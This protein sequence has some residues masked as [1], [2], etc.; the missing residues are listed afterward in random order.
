MSKIF[1]YTLIFVFI[2]IF[3][4]SLSLILQLKGKRLTKWFGKHTF[5]IHMLITGILW[6]ITFILVFILQFEE[7]PKF[8]G[9]VILKYTGLFLF[10]SGSIIT[11]WASILLGIKRLLC[12]NFFEEDVPIINKSL[13]K[14][15]NNPVDY[16]FWAAL[17]GFAIF[18]GSFYN[19]IIAIEFIILMAPHIKL[20]N[21]P[22]KKR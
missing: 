21:I 7:H 11:I 6:I 1:I 2:T 20:E 19:L 10:G 22:L 4:E 17:I 18:T 14:Y 13:Y 12:L 5:K 15:I 3:V 8:H 16:G 9:S